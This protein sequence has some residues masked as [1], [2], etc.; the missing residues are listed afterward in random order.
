[1]I[2]CCS[3]DWFIMGL[4]SCLRPTYFQ[5]KQRKTQKEIS[6]WRPIS[7]LVL[8]PKLVL[9]NS[10]QRIISVH[11]KW[12]T[13]FHI[14]A[15][16]PCK[17]CF[18]THI[19]LGTFAAVADNKLLLLIWFWTVNFLCRSLPHSTPLSSHHT[20]WIFND[21]CLIKILLNIH[22]CSA[23][24]FLWIAAFHLEIWL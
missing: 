11:I 10:L 21:C 17:Q 6:Q 20:M 14:D 13:F 23:L 12:L 8:N 7:A 22:K 5:N 15:K 3:F 24:T 4:G 1:M 2:K 16:F 18:F 19:L 9:N